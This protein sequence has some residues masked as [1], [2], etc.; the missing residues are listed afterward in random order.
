VSQ[1]GES[2]PRIPIS[3]IKSAIIHLSARKN[4]ILAR[5]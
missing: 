1:A 2:S 5:K 3:S 4:T